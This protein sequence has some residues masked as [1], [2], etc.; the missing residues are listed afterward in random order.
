MAFIK[1]E[2]QLDE[3]TLA[4]DFNVEPL[5]LSSTKPQSSGGFFNLQNYLK[6]NQT[7]AANLGSDVAQKIKEPIAQ[8]TILSDLPT[9]IWN[10]Q[11]TSKLAE[12]EQG[13]S[14]IL[15]DIQP[16]TT[17]GGV[18]LNQFLVSNNPTARSYIQNAQQ[19]V[20]NIASG[21]DNFVRQLRE[22]PYV[23]QSSLVTGYNPISAEVPVN[24]Q[25]TGLNEDQ[26][27]YLR[28]LKPYEGPAPVDYSS[29]GN[30]ITGIG[31]AAGAAALA[32]GIDAIRRQGGSVTKQGNQIIGTINNVRQAWNA[33]KG[34]FEPIGGGDNIDAGGG[35]NPATG[36]SIHPDSMLPDNID[37]GGGW[38]PATGGS[39]LS[40]GIGDNIDAGGGWNPA[41]AAGASAVT[42]EMLAAANA[43]PDPIGT[44]NQLAGWTASASA[45]TPELLALANASA[46]PIFTLNAAMGW[47]GGGASAAPAAAAAAEAAAT[48][49]GTGA[50]SMAANNGALWAVNNAGNYASASE[51]YAAAEAAA[52]TAEGGLGLGGL[53]PMGTAFMYAAAAYLAVKYGPEVIE[54]LGDAAHHVGTVVSDTVADIGQG[55][56]DIIHDV[57]TPISDVVHAVTSPIVETVSNVVASAG[58]AVS[59]VAT[60]VFRA[61]GSVVCT[62]L[63]RQG[64]LPTRYYIPSAREFMSYPEQGK[65]GYYLWSKPLVKHLQK[66]PTS[67]LSNAAEK[68][69]NIRSE[70]IAA[71]A[72]IKGAKKSLAGAIL[73]KG[74]YGICWTLGYTVCY[75]P[76][77]ED[78]CNWR[79]A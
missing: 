33:S 54:S 65:K 31:A 40:A 36:G 3:S 9:N 53:G 66:H 38:N 71:K 41:G 28:S 75:L 32:A 2:D 43:S 64:R 47:T 21:Y 23:D 10:A 35:W 17:T 26:I 77:L 27:A 72:G 79:T 59:D 42:P 78:K 8:T 7:G 68:L 58:Q 12:S 5:S 49:A 50:T 57:T 63:N 62:E 73:D 76:V 30:S 74:L 61:A 45:V 24:T 55:V 51:A 13:R 29:L 14:Q 48:Y 46:D 22:N 67:M 60:S 18:D 15:S 16:K 56:S 34:L 70:H 6:A 39:D 4:T 25:Y 37:A 69:F 44:L 19:D 1:P 11:D 52:A 20:S